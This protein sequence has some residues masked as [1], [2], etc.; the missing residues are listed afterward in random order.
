MKRKIFPIGAAVG[1]LA[2]VLALWKG[3]WAQA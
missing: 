3:W 2:L 1:I